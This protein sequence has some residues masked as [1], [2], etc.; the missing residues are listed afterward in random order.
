MKI[1]SY[2]FDVPEFNS[3]NV[4][5]I[6]DTIKSIDQIS[7]KESQMS[8]VIITSESHLR[9]HLLEDA[10][11]NEIIRSTSIRV[12]ASDKR[13]KKYTRPTLIADTFIGDTLIVTR[14]H[15]QMQELIF[16]QQWKKNQFI[17][18]T[19]DHLTFIASSMSLTPKD[20]SL[21]SNINS[22]YNDRIIDENTVG[23]VA[24]RQSINSVMS[25]ERDIYDLFIALA[26]SNIPRSFKTMSIATTVEDEIYS[27]R[28][29]LEILTKFCRT[30]LMDHISTL[31]K[32]IAYAFI[33][34]TLLL[35]IVSQLYRPIDTSILTILTLSISILVSINA[36]NSQQVMISKQSFAAANKRYVAGNAIVNQINKKN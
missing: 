12:V 24:S 27:D 30:S 15:Y 6:V 13:S 8:E 33:C 16:A 14:T 2:A 3:T 26:T 10:L 22:R 32:L 34:V 31:E 1:I 11:K 5:K 35:Q 21:Y 36:S 19:S 25:S 18:I 29:S 9:D 4:P 23:F 7:E 28:E 17:E 20:R